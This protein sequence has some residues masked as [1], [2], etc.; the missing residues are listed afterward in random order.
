RPA[1]RF[2]AVGDINQSIYGFRHADPQVF[3][4]YRSRLRTEGKHLAEL[5]ES[6][7]SR[8]DILRAVMWLVGGQAAI[9]AHSV[10]PVRK[11]R[12]KSQPS[13]EVIRCWADDSED[14][15]ALEAK[16]VARRIGELQG[17]L[18]LEGGPARFGDMA[19]LVRKADSI[20]AFTAAFDEAGIPY[21]GTAG[22]GLFGGREV[23]D[24]THLLRVLANPR[25]EIS[26][27]AVLRSPLI[28][29]SDATLLRLKQDGD[30]A[31]E[32]GDLAAWRESRH[33]ISA[34]RLLIRAM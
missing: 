6:W 30:L 9:E 15:L 22:K 18:A 1:D 33:S 28:G 11:F 12:R 32:A 10:Q 20:R 34:D 24:L 13:V 4:A 26:M 23:S 5:R 14:A 2:Y 31:A 25:D 19:A 17:T 16:W 7:R 27:A 21:L 3:D 8:G 29:V